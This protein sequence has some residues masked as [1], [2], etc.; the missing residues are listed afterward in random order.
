MKWLALIFSSTLLLACS[1]KTNEMSKEQK[2]EY[3]SLGDSISAHTQ[4]VL[5]KNVAQQIKKGGVE[6][7]LEYCHINASSLTDS[8]ARIYSGKIWRLSDKN[9]N[10]NNTI[11]TAIDQK[12]WKEFS[13]NNV[14]SGVVLQDSEEVFYYKPIRLGMPTCLKCHGIEDEDISAKT[15]SVIKQ[16]YPEDKATG[17]SLE[18]LRGMWKIKIK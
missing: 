7:A 3:L 5:L 8:L 9:R 12:A 2:D 1:Q 10:S 13:Q 15:L 16:K 14:M 11:Q 18:E 17:Y 4:S 6:N